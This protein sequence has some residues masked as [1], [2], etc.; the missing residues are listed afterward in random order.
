MPSAYVIVNSTVTNPAQ[1]E[2]YKKLSTAAMQAYGAE[3]CIRGG[4]VEVAEGDWVPDRLVLLKFSS[5]DAAR[6]FESSPEYAKARVARQ[7]AAIMR[8]VI[9]EGV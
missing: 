4:A 9:A 7:G 1:Y 5:M 2:D 6:R 8:M 3:I